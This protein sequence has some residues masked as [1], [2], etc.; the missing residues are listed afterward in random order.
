MDKIYAKKAGYFC[1]DLK[2]QVKI[3][4]DSIVDMKYLT[5]LTIVEFIE[6]KIENEKII[7]GIGFPV[8]VSVNNICAHD[9]CIDNNDK[10]VFNLEK[11]LIKIDFGVHIDGIIIDNAFTYTRNPNLSLLVN[12]SEYLV[13]EVIKSIKKDIGISTIQS[14]ADNLLDK[15]NTDNNTNF[16]AISN[17]AGHKIEKYK[18]HASDEQLIYANNIVNGNSKA[19]IQGDSYYAIE[20]FISNGLEKFPQ[21][22]KESV[23]HFMVNYDKLKKLN[24]M[25]IH[26]KDYDSVRNVIVENCRTLAFCQRFILKNTDL[27]LETINEILNSFFEL[28]ILTKYPP[29]LDLNSDAAVSQY[30]LTIYVPD[31]TQKMAEILS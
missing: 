12:A 3:F 17:L 1:R 19:Q 16:I 7:D 8:G 27:S 31:D 25:K 15:F 26:N 6:K 29:I 21:M 14:L 24:K 9:T 23:S 4:L 18:I 2:E 30:E 10:R 11:D 22:D 20:F 28:G 13:K 5:L